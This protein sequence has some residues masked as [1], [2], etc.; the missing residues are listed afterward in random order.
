MTRRRSPELLEKISL[1]MYASDIEKMKAFYPQFGYSVAIRAL[2]RQHVQNVLARADAV[3]DLS[4]LDNLE[5]E[6]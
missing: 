2:V 5:I 4:T 6:I 1:N 3:I